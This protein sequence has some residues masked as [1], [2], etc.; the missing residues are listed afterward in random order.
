MKCLS[1]TLLGIT[2]SVFLS[3]QVFSECNPDTTAPVLSGVPADVSLE[4]ANGIP[5]PLTGG[6]PTPLVTATD[7]CDANPGVSFEVHFS[8]GGPSTIIVKRTWTATDAS[9]NS[10]MATQTINIFD[11]TPPEVQCNASNITVVDGEDDEVSFTATSTDACSGVTTEVGWLI[12]IEPSQDDA[13][14]PWWYEYEPCQVTT[15]YGDDDDDDHPWWWWNANSAP[16]LRRRLS[17]GGRS[18]ID[19]FA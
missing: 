2:L 7:E 11:N 17:Q 10:S 4:C 19:R 18:P 3:A 13:D 6:I 12:C 1:T 5:P 16:R 9:G 15:I 14:L 8:D